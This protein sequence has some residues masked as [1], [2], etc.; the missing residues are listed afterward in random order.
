[1]AIVLDGFFFFNMNEYIY[2]YEQ[3]WIYPL[4]HVW[5]N[6]AATQAAMAWFILI[7]IVSFV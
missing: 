3:L 1:M 5:P 4:D 7:I 6:A 2:T